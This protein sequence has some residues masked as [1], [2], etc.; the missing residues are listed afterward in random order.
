MTDAAAPGRERR[1]HRR[2]PLD[3]PMW[4]VVGGKRIPA[5]AVNV[6]V[7]GAAIRTNARASVGA[8]VELEVEHFGRRPFTLDAEVVRAEH[9]VLALR[10]LALRQRALESL[11][12]L[13]GVSDD[14]DPSGVRHVGTEAAP[15]SRRK[16]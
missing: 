2:G 5:G 11:L 15:D 16:A 3:A 12:G 13:S 14:D 4:I 10:F 9:G 1:I 7:G 8:I 6:S